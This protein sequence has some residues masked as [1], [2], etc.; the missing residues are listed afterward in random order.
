MKFLNSKQVIS[1]LIQVQ[2][3]LLKYWNFL[4]YVAFLL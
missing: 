1:H 3:K 4:K 2:F